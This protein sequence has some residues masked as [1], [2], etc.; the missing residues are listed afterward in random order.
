MTTAT[1]LP[2]WTD[3]KLNDKQAFL[4]AWELEQLPPLNPDARKN[5]EEMVIHVHYSASDFHFY[6]AQFDPRTGEFFGFVD[7]GLGRREW[8]ILPHHEL[9]LYRDSAGKMGMERDEYWIPKT[10]S[11]MGL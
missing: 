5:A 7:F 9:I 2:P 10:T 3:L 8:G 11:A 1:T 6:A 4:T